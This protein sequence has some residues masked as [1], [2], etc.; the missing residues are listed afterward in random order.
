[1]SRI[2]SEWLLQ[3][4]VKERD[5]ATLSMDVDTFKAFY[6]KW[7]AK[8]VYTRPL[9]DNDYII[10]IAIRKAVCELA[11]PPADKLKEAQEWLNERGFTEGI[12]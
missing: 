9:P 5:E 1:M 4:F 7:K 2:N 10:E 6:Q 12:A 11:N 8:G 3:Q